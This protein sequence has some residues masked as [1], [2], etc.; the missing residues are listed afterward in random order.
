MTEDH[1][2]VINASEGLD[3]CGYIDS[4]FK[5]NVD[6]YRYKDLVMECFGKINNNSLRERLKELS[7]NFKGEIFLN[8]NHKERFYHVFHRKD[9]DI[10][11]ISPRYIAVLFLLIDDEMLL[12][13]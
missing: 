5:V 13:L 4:D 1:C 7:K 11:E 6:K 12:R 8:Y 3:K 10:R 2:N 9:I